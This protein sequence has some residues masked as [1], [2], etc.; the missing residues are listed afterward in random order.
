MPI[1]GVSS[2]FLSKYKKAFFLHGVEGLKLAHKGSI[3]IL[4]QQ[5]RVEIM[6]W[7]LTKESSTLNELEYYISSKYGEDSSPSKATTIYLKKHVLVG[8]KLKLIILN[9]TQSR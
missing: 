9:M 6:E 1:L 3:G 4:N 7:L 5:Q 2:G 8:K